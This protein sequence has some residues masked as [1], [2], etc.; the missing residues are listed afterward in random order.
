MSDLGAIC[1]I[2]SFKLCRSYAL[3]AIRIKFSPRLANA[4]AAAAPIPELAPVMTIYFF[5][6]YPFLD[7]LV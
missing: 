3:R 1:A 5:I 6:F 4:F 7:S 2:S